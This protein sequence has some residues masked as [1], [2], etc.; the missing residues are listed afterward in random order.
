[1]AISYD[2]YYSESSNGTNWKTAEQNTYLGANNWADM[3][4]GN[5]YIVAIG[6]G[7]YISRKRI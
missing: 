3:T 4:V 5:G 2:G 6:Y 1:M 7:G